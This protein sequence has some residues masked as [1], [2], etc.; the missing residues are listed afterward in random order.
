[1]LQYEQ[2]FPIM[3]WGHAEQQ[4]HFVESSNLCAWRIAAARP[5]VRLAFDEYRRG[6]A[7]QIKFVGL[8]HLESYS[9]AEFGL[10]GDACL[11]EI[12]A[13]GF[14]KFSPDVGI[15]DRAHPLKIVFQAPQRSL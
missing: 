12:D 5:C 6:V 11:P 2:D 15:A 1:M 4:H 3:I 8:L 7:A 13:S 9:Y 10:Q 14:L